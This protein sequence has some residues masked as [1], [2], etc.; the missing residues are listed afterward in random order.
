MNTNL[1]VKRRS[2][3]NFFWL[4]SLFVASGC[5]YADNRRAIAFGVPQGY[6]GWIRVKFNIKGAAP[7]PVRNGCYIAR[8]PANGLLRTS[9]VEGE[10]WGSDS[11]Y[12]VT[13]S[14][15]EILLPTNGGGPNTFVWGDAGRTNERWMFIGV[16]KQFDDAQKL[17]GGQD[18]GPLQ[19]PIRSKTP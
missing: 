2:Y 9:T 19:L 17:I 18:P 11:F 5:T 3:L 4:F 12:Y 14:G 16:K 8:I 6:V 7:L 1:S 13:K 15:N 10:G